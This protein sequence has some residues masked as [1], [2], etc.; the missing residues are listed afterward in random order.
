MG[1]GERGA[2][3]SGALPLELWGG[4]ECTINRIGDRYL[5]QIALSAHDRRPD[6]LERFAAL[7]I[8][9]LR[10]PLLRESFARSDD[11]PALWAWHDA[12][13]ER[14]RALGIRPVLGLIHHGSGPRSTD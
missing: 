4:V 13:L 6:D 8:A 3:D 11:A 1:K 9:A 7:G 12:R 10:Y 2:L 14:L 5:D